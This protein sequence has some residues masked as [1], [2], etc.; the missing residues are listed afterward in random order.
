[1]AVP[2]HKEMEENCG[3]LCTTDDRGS[4]RAG[5]LVGHVPQLHMAHSELHVFPAQGPS[6]ITIR[7]DVDFQQDVSLL[8]R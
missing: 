5:H 1:M 4:V 2:P 6:F 8:V 3:L 7:I